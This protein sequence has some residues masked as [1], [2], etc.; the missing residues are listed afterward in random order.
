M[1]NY[2]ITPYDNF[3]CIAEKCKHSCCVGWQILID[4]KTLKSY[5]KLNDNEKAGIDFKK[6]CFKL[7]ENKRCAF[8]DDEGLCKLINQYGKDALCQ[9][10]SDHPRYRNYFKGREEM[11]LGLTCE[12]ACRQI[13]TFNGKMKAVPINDSSERLSSF[14]RR[15]LAFR[16]E[17]LSIVQNRSLHINEKIEK[18]VAI[19][20][21]NLELPLSFYATWLTKVECLD[22]DWQELLKKCLNND[23]LITAVSVDGIVFEQLLS[24]FVFR[25][26]SKAISEKELRCLLVFSLFSALMVISI[27]TQTG[28][29][30]F[31]IAR[32]Y[33]SEIEYSENNLN[34]LYEFSETILSKNCK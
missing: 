23:S 19:S 17:V 22:K 8:L 15:V 7:D 3:N 28:V 4:K 20:N 34:S 26:V 5:K 1:K 24:Y 2:L 29:D 10:C 27:H 31:E 16:E 11:G 18:L 21:A 14:E 33:S 9:V 13:L 25:H 30:V 12:E 6:S 32:L